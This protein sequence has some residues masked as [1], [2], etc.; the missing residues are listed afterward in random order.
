MLDG[1]EAI[2]IGQAIQHIACNLPADRQ[3]YLS[4]L[5]IKNDYNGGNEDEAEMRVKELRIVAYKKL[6]ARR[7][8]VRFKKFVLEISTGKRMSRSS[9]FHKTDCETCNEYYSGP[10]NE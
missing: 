10:S 2:R 6:A 5:T 7:M 8:E 9:N 1:L 3:L 4:D